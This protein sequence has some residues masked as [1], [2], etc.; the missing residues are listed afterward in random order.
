[1]DCGQLEIVRNTLNWSPK[2]KKK[3][4]HS[5]KSKVV[6]AGSPLSY[7]YSDVS[8]PLAG[9]M[10][11]KDKVLFLSVLN[12]LYKYKS[13]LFQL[14]DMP[15]QLS[16]WTSQLFCAVGAH[17]LKL[18]DKE[19]KVRGEVQMTEQRFRWAKL[20]HFISLLLCTK[21]HAC[22]CLCIQKL[23]NEAL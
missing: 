2:V 1:M 9:I 6:V 16:R 18:S 7:F 22:L 5:P 19:N 15:A 8:E 12:S 21:E 23:T 13:R 20:S 10:P 3:S 14:T 4:V 17:L 11:V